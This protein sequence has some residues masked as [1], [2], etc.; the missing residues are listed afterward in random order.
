[1]RDKFVLPVILLLV[2]LGLYHSLSGEY[3]LDD[4]L[5]F[6]Q[7]EQIDELAE[8]PQIWNIQFSKVDYRPVA[9]VTF[10][11][12]KIF[13]SEFNPTVSHLIN[14]I[15]YLLSITV[16]YLFSRK[17]FQHLYFSWIA[18]ALF[19][20]L[21]LHTSMVANVKSRDG[22]LSFLFGIT[23]LYLITLLMSGT[24]RLKQM[25]YIFLVFVLFYL[26]IFSKLDGLMILLSIP[27][28]FILNLNF[29]AIKLAAKNTLRVLIISLIV[30]RAATTVFDFWHETK[31]TIVADLPVEE[32]TDPLIFTEN[33]IIAYDGISYKLAYTIQTVFEYIKM[34]FS[35]K[36]HYFYFGY[37]ML[38]VLPLN[39]SIIIAKGI[40]LLALV[41]SALFFIIKHAVYSYGIFFMFLSL[42]YCA[43]FIQPI[44]GIIADRYAFISSAGAS[45]ALAYFIVRC[46]ELLQSKGTLK[47]ET[48][49]FYTITFILI[50]L[51]YIPFNFVRAKEW[52]TFHSLLEADMP[53]LTERSYE[54]NRIAMNRYIDDGFE[55]QNHQ[56]KINFLNKGIHYAQAALKVYDGNY[57]PYEGLAL[58]Y[59]GLGNF[60][61]AKKRA[62]VASA[63]FDTT[64][65]TTYRILYEI[66]TQEEKT[67]SVLWALEH[68][69][70]AVPNDNFLILKYAETAYIL[71]KKDL[72]M[73]FCDSILNR[74][75]KQVA[76]YQAR[77][78]IHFY[79][80]DS[81][82]GAED[83]ERAFELGLNDETLFN[84]AGIYWMSRDTARAERLWNLVK[85]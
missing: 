80:Q 2:T 30:F 49:R 25:L 41:F 51:I 38:E 55:T 77:A 40:V 85:N 64:L 34:M 27:L 66:Y 26:S 65:E 13:I 8:L 58:G 75:N 1:M 74:N 10:A 17:I 63:K 47:M 59:F 45:I 46:F 18:T 4:Y 44:A 28:L 61:E 70:K 54:A 43:N 20:F 33:P 50:I 42:T 7:I 14:L 24:T 48:Q 32:T 12:E 84:A 6:T 73:N 69:N 68:L 62:L 72:A 76:A 82:K 71:D 52:K 56:D 3:N 60:Q 21:P 11:L 35:P 53:K 19:A 23:A 36:G 37:D 15:I 9:S 22:L 78:Y 5:Y 79:S 16:F 83:A 67:D 31:N 29:S 57:L 39:N 81:L